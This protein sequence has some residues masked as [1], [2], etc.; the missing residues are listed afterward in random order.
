MLPFNISSYATL[1]LILESVTGHKALGIQGNLKKV[2]LYDNSFSAVEEQLGR[3]ASEEKATLDL[4]GVYGQLSEMEPK[5]SSFYADFVRTLYNNRETLMLRNY[6]PQ[7]A[8][9]VKMLGRD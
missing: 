3:I 2:H 4:E 1:A 5:D 8:I 9:S 7:K 6:I